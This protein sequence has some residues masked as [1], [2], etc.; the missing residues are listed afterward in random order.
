ME[1][2]DVLVWG[3]FGTGTFGVPPSAA[4][5]CDHRARDASAGDRFPGFSRCRHFLYVDTNSN[6]D[7]AES[8]WPISTS[9]PQA[10]A[11]PESMRSSVRQAICCGLAK[12]L[13]AQSFDTEKLQLTGDGSGCRSSRF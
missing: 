8:M 7:R 13:V 2:R 10:V 1:R 9:R 6:P 12:T 5:H 3:G 4:A 11:C